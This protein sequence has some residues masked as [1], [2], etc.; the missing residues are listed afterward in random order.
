MADSSSGEMKRGAWTAQED[1]LLLN[2]MASHGMDAGGWTTLPIKA[3]L[4]RS[5]KS[6]RFRWMNHL[7]PN[8]NHGNISPDEKELIIRLHRLLGNRW[9]LIAGR[10]PG[11]T[12]N[13][14]KNYW[15]THLSTKNSSKQLDQKNCEY[16]KPE[17]QA[18]HCCEIPSG[19]KESMA[20]NS[21]QYPYIFP[22]E[23]PCTSAPAAISL[24]PEL[25]LSFPDLDWF[26]NS[27][28]DSPIIDFPDPNYSCAFS[29]ELGFLLPEENKF[30]G[31]NSC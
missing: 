7:K 22:R 24:F 21:E 13:Q 1:E 15:N 3:G 12:D 27:N 2:Y 19:T 18:K 25:D 17:K 20:Q 31:N 8:I 30:H 11:R 9:S 6:C 23:Y 5:G 29:N 14:I 16:R 10:L 28:L 4:R 26:C